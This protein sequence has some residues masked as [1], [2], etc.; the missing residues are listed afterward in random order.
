MHAT[1]RPVLLARCDLLPSR[2]RRPAMCTLDDE[3]RTIP[4]M[5][6]VYSLRCLCQ[7]SPHSHCVRRAVVVQ[8]STSLAKFCAMCTRRSP[9]ARSTSRRSP[10]LGTGATS[11]VSIQRTQA[12]MLVDQLS[13][14]GSRSVRSR[15][16]PSSSCF[17]GAYADCCSLSLSIYLRN[18][19]SF[20]PEPCD[21]GPEPAVRKPTPLF[22]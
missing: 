9:G 16:Q 1:L 15:S 2:R 3:A 21:Q 8:S 5:P 20:R 18:P 17:C 6:F 7:H 19:A 10:R 12:C 14:C 11:T 22:K 4:L 13:H